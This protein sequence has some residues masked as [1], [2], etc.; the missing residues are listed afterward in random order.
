MG[1]FDLARLAAATADQMS[2]LAEDKNIQSPAP[3]PNRCG[4]KAT[5]RA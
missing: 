1:E 2:L 5:R 4:W 3:P